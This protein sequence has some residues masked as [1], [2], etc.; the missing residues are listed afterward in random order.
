MTTTASNGAR[1]RVAHIFRDQS[2]N[3][4]FREGWLDMNQ[5][6]ETENKFSQNVLISYAD[7]GEEA[8]VPA[9][10]I[11]ILGTIDNK[12]LVVGHLVKGANGI[13]V[14]KQGVLALA[15]NEAETTGFIIYDGETSPVKVD[16]SEL[17]VLG[18]C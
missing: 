7:N 9:S 17:V 6:R 2:R 1:L 5:S 3:I 4:H 16:L 18:N 8:L 14:F 12:R 13:P 15:N 10:E 11:K